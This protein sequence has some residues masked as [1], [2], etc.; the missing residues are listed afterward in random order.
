MNAEVKDIRTYWIFGEWVRILIDRFYLHYGTNKLIVFH[1]DTEKVYLEEMQ[2]DRD[3][4]IFTI[5]HSKVKELLGDV[6]EYYV[7]L[8]HEG[9]ISNMVLIELITAI[10]TIKLQWDC[11]YTGK[12][13]WDE[14][15]LWLYVK[16]E[17]FK[18]WIKEKFGAD[19]QTNVLYLVNCSD[20]ENPTTH[21]NDDYYSFK[22][23]KNNTEF[24]YWLYDDSG[25]DDLIYMDDS[26]GNTQMY[27]LSNHRLP[28]ELSFDIDIDCAVSEQ[29]AFLKG[30]WTKTV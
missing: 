23:T 6:S 15:G 24:E 29:Y 3:F 21:E 14:V 5:E 12:I 22:L 25:T 7:Y 1:N 18:Q 16:T 26:D 27:I 13:Y 11:L 4:Q 9:L 8:N 28:N 20:W 2:P 19:L 30:S 17:D 10:T